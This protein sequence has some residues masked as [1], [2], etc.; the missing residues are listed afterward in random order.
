M[1]LI[2]LGSPQDSIYPLEYLIENAKTYGH[3]ILAVVSQARKTNYRRGKQNEDTPLASFAR[4]VGILTLQPEKAS[5]PEFQNTLRELAPDVMITCAYGQILN[6]SFLNIPTRATINIHP[7]LLPK[8]RG[9]TPVQTALLDGLQ[10]TGVT[11]LFTVKEL[12]AG[13]II[14]QKKE[15]IFP[16]EVSGDLMTRLFK[17]SAPLL[18]EA[19][20]ALADPNFLGTPQNPKD[21]SLCKKIKKEDGLIDWSLDHTSILNRFRAYNPW[22]ASFTFLHGKRII[23]ASL[24]D[25]EKFLTETQEP[26]SFFFKKEDQTLNVACKNAYLK[27]KTLKPEG[28]RILNAGEFWN[29]LKDRDHL[30]FSNL[31]VE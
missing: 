24:E 26:G 27:V 5:D 13:N 9:A 18:I 22:P 7:S 19:L 11:I 1:R 17:I 23:L 20:D 28:S 16:N 4:K 10:E 8:Y 30:K 21:V 31:G 6:Q 3:E 12:D 2:Y 29:G 25:G 14:L 15:A